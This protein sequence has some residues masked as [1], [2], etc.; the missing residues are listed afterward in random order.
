[1]KKH[2]KEYL[3][4]AARGWIGSMLIALLL[5]TSFKSAIAD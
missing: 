1:M 3:S 4:M 5:A 2:F